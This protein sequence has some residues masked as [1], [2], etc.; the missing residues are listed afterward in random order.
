[1]FEPIFHLHKL[2]KLKEVNFS[3]NSSDTQLYYKLVTFYALQTRIQW[4]NWK[5]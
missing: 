3:A 4:K 1:M 5:L 2:R